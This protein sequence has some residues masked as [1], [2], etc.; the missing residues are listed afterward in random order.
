MQLL[1][2]LLWWLVHV[3]RDGTWRDSWGLQ[4]TWRPCHSG[5]SILPV[6]P[7][8]NWSL[9]VRHNNHNIKSTTH[10]PPTLPHLS[11][12]YLRAVTLLPLCVPHFGQVTLLFCLNSCFHAATHSFIDDSGY[13]L[14]VQEHRMSNATGLVKDESF[15]SL[16]T[17][18]GKKLIFPTLQLSPPLGHWRP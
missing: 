10:A 9:H 7:L 6:P 14:H 4:P 5:N 1:H 3:H 11:Q 17:S 15:S 18:L 12:W 8:S 13:S 16:T 2:L